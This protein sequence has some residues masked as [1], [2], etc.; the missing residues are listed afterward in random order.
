[1]GL[2][3]PKAKKPSFSGFPDDITAD[4]TPLR[5]RPRVTGTVQPYYNSLH[6]REQKEWKEVG[7]AEPA[8]HNVQLCNSVLYQ[9]NPREK[10]T[11]R[12]VHVPQ[13]H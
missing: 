9:E 10:K 7:E 13:C 8:N 5:A 12:R 4:D 6:G 2:P 3:N 1:M 11:P